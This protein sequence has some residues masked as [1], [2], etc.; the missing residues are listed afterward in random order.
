LKTSAS[1]RFG[2]RVAGMEFPT[3]ATRMIVALGS[4]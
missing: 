4:D 1:F 2:R 3:R